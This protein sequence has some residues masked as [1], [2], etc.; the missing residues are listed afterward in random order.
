MTATYETL[1]LDHPSPDILRVTLNRPEVAN[2]FNT[3]MAQDLM[4]FFEAT[5]LDPGM[6]RV[7]IV[8]GAGERA[9]CAGGDLK[10]RDGMSDAAWAAQHLIYVKVGHLG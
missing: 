9:F 1:L 8:T 2:A 3:A 10:E 6:A 4:T 7:I 5:T